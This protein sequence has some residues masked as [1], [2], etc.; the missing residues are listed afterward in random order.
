MEL[1]QLLLLLPCHSLEDFPTHFR[2]QDALDLLLAWTTLWHPGLLVASGKMPSWNRCEQPPDDCDGHAILIPQ[3]SRNRLPSGFLARCEEQGGYCLESSGDRDRDAATLLEQFQ[4]GTDGAAK[5]NWEAE[6]VQDF[7]ALSY[8]YLQIQLL[9][10]QLRYS[11]NLDEVH[12]EMQLLKAAQAA[13]QQDSAQLELALDRCYDVLSE[14][15]HRYYP[16]DSYLV[17]LT[18]LAPTTLG[19]R[20]R[21]QLE[22]EQP[23][24]YLVDQTLLQQLEQQDAGLFAYLQ[25]RHSEGKVHFVGGGKFDS[26]TGLL[27]Y[28]TLVQQA[29][30]SQDYFESRFGEPLRIYARRSPGIEQTLPSV[31][32]RVGYH[33]ALHEVFDEGKLYS[34]NSTNFRWE[35]PDGQFVNSLTKTV[36][37][38]EQPHTFLR[39]GIQVGE[40]LDVD[41]LAVMQLVH[42]PGQVSPIYR[43]LVRSASRSDALGKWA[44]LEEVFAI[45]HEPG[46]GESVNST[47][48]N[49]PYLK[50]LKQHGEQSPFD[51]ARDL[52]KAEASSRRVKNLAAMAQLASGKKA[53]ATLNALAVESLASES[54]EKENL[55]QQVLNSVRGKLTGTGDQGLLLLNPASQPQ[56]VLLSPEELKGRTLDQVPDDQVYHVARGLT[57]S[58]AVVDVPAM[59]YLHLA[60]GK[61]HSQKSA[62]RNPGKVL[63]KQTTM[64]N[65]FLEVTVDTD[66]GS[67]RSIHNYEQ[68]SNLCSLQL[69]WFDADLKKLVAASLKKTSSGDWRENLAQ[70]WNRK[71]DPLEK[72]LTLHHGGY[73]K[74]VAESVKTIYNNSAVAEIRS[75]GT[76]CIRKKVVADFLVDYRLVRGSRY[77]EVRAQVT[78]RMD[79]QDIKIKKE[80]VYQFP[81][82]AISVRYSWPGLMRILRNWWQPV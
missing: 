77:V 75:Q 18:L 76:L 3:V 17:D 34:T 29:K 49:A 23:H 52:L 57:G 35:G 63:V 74:M 53:D 21:Q 65:E 5:V 70:L 39:L 12:F 4:A 25:Q 33:A 32:T 56:R 60:A 9:T 40:A 38:A 73:T 36:L 43:D 78:P 42:W 51:V 48:Y 1:K 16:M 15:R 30:D 71:S 81:N 61:L 68:R 58:W 64:R 72:Q 19:S 24:N 59:G 7:Y 6:V 67:L 2:D 46:Y 62:T 47:D 50:Q 55:E 80:R 14:E 45:V 10:R 69:A 44:T 27:S 66:T 28:Q 8:T 26:P 79:H 37:D 11:S 22:S 13:A 54:A 41:H 31:L 20:F 82:E